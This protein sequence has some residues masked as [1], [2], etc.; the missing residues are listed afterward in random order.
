MHEAGPR[1]AS[2]MSMAAPLLLSEYA[3]RLPRFFR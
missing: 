2:P 1:A 3:L